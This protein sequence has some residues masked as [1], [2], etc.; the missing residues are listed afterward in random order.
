MNSLLLEL[1]RLCHP[2]CQPIRE[3]VPF[4]NFYNDHLSKIASFSTI[5]MNKLDSLLDEILYTISSA[6]RKQYHSFRRGAPILVYYSVFIVV[7][8]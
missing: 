4:L 5:T 6:L 8:L 7:I 1:A 2:S 3:S